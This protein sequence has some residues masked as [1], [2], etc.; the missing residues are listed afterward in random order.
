MNREEL[1]QDQRVL[2]EINKHLWIESEKT[3]HD[4]G[5]EAAAEDWL[6][7]YAKAWMDYHL[8]QQKED[9]AIK[10]NSQ[11]KDKKNPPRA[12]ASKRR[13]AKSFIL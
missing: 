1:L 8:P 4:I 12:K 13:R 7:R 9:P 2:D 3:G 6:S 5:F 10:K 11:I